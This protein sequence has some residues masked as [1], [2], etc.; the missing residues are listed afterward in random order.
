MSIIKFMKL[1]GDTPKK[2]NSN[3]PRILERGLN[4]KKMKGLDSVNAT[5]LFL[6]LLKTSGF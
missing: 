1:Y 4:L 5:G 6:Y 3:V 2:F